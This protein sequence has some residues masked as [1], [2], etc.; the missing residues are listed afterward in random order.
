MGSLNIYVEKCKGISFIYLNQSSETA[1]KMANEALKYS[2]NIPPTLYK[3]HGEQIGIYI[4]RDLD[5]SSVYRI[6]IQ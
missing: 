6:E 1:Q 4:A 3:N 5:F 2:I